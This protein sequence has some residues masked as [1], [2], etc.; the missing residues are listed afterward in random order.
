MPK[1][2][3]PAG[4][5]PACRTLITNLAAESHED[6]ARRRQSFARRRKIKTFFKSLITD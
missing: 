1:T 3:P 2:D 5:D 4:R 6:A